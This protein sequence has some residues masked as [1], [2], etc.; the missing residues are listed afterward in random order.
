MMNSL[1]YI[2]GAS[3]LGRPSITS[4]LYGIPVESHTESRLN[5]GSCSIFYFNCFAFGKLTTTVGYGI[6][7]PVGCMVYVQHAFVG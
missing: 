4:L 7:G 5:V 6:I 3:L 1:K 2:L